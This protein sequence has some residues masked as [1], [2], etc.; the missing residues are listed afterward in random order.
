MST[1]SSPSTVTAARKSG[2]AGR[3]RPRPLSRTSRTVVPGGWAEDPHVLA[4]STVPCARAAHRLDHARA[5]YLDAAALSRSGWGRT[6]T[7]SRPPTRRGRRCAAPRTRSS[8][9]VGRRSRPVGRSRSARA[10]R[11]GR[12]RPSA[13][14]GRRRGRRAPDPGRRLGDARDPRARVGRDVRVGYLAQLG[15][16]VAV[17]QRA[18][19]LGLE[20]LLQRAGAHEPLRSSTAVSE[21]CS[22]VTSARV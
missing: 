3:A 22:A 5:A 18:R 14:V 9:G 12:C 8:G 19:Q 15:L 4:R 10:G 17:A 1:T 20:E 11:R 7:P 13:R 2:I 6:A 16:Q 21:P